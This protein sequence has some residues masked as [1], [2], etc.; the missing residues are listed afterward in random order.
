MLEQ[1][2]TVTITFAGLALFCLKKVN[3]NDEKTFGAF[4]AAILQCPTHDLVIDILEITIDPKTGEQIGSKLF[5]HSPDKS[6]NIKIEAVNPAITDIK[7]KPDGVEKYEP[8]VEFDRVRDVGDPKDFRWIID[9]EGEQ[10]GGQKLALKPHPS[11]TEPKQ[12]GPIITVNNGVVYTEK[13]SDEK[14]AVISINNGA[15]QPQLLGRL[16]YKIGVDITCNVQNGG[17]VLL[18]QEDT[19]IRLPP[20]NAGPN[21]RY[22]IT[23]ENFCP[24]SEELRE[25]TDFR[26]IFDA[27]SNQNGERFDLQ[28]VVENGGR[29]D[30]SET[31]ANHPD[32]S[33]DAEEQPCMGGLVN[34][35]DGFPVG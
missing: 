7:R 19:E 8:A 31:L 27:I 35:P 23:I 17:A 25:G 4:Q 16:A 33:L 1:R 12:L 3:E 30:V 11:V 6:Q 28:R 32:F 2:P 21:Q 15:G 26:F 9:L 20:L 14:F 13:R 22:L 5:S 29:G 10:F 34:P 18:K 24:P